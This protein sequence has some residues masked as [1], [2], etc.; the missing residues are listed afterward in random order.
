MGEDDEPA[1]APALET[2]PADK[3]VDRTQLE[4]FYTDAGRVV[5]GGGGIRPDIEIDQ[6]FL[7]DFEVAVERD[8]ALFSFAVDYVAAHPQMPADFQVTDEVF[9]QFAAHLKGRE[10]I[11][12]YLEVFKL[13][14]SDSLVNANADFLNRGIRREL[15]RRA[16]GQEAA[17]RVAIEA[18]TQLHHALDL[19]RKGRTLPELMVLAAEWNKAE[20]AKA[21]AT[22]ATKDA[23]RN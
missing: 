9:R 2:D 22:T 21:A 18:D 14:Y 15:A 17:Y 19:F 4:K 5:Y 10:K 6:D 20:L 12:E 16:H 7:G 3:E 11:G 8:G 1:D 13:T 23:V